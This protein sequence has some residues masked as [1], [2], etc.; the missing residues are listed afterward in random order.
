MPPKRKPPHSPKPSA[1]KKKA[2][3][4]KPTKAQNSPP[5]P[6][7]S[8]KTSQRST[9]TPRSKSL[10]EPVERPLFHIVGI[11]ASAGGLEAFEEFFTHMSPTSGL[12]FVVVPHQ[13]P[14]HASL[15]PSLLQKCTTMPVRE[16]VD[17]LLLE[18]NTVS[19]AL[20]GKNLGL[21]NGTLQVMEPDPQSRVPLPIDY[22]FRSLAVDQQQWAIGII[23][24]GTGSDGTLGLKTIKAES[25]FT[26]AQKPSSAKYDGMPQSAIGRG[27]VDLVCEPTDM[28]EQL[29]A[30]V[31]KTALSSGFALPDSFHNTA[32]E[33]Q[34][35]IMLLRDRT[36][37]DFSVYKSKT[38]ERRI[39]RR[40]N[41]HQIQT[42]PEYGRY[43]AAN[44]HESEVLF[45]E[46]LIGVT[47]F[48]RDPPVFYALVNQGFPLWFKSKSRDTPIRVWVPGCSTG[49][50][51]YTLAML[52]SEYQAKSQIKCPIQIFGTDL[53]SQAIATARTGLYPEGIANDVMSERLEQFFTQEDHHYRVKKA[54]RDM[55]IF[56]P[57]NVLTDPP[58]M[59][60][61]FI[62]CRNLFIYLLSHAQRRLIPLFHYALNP[63]GGLLLGSSETMSENGSNLFH[64]LNHKWKLY[65][66]QPGEAARPLLSGFAG[67]PVPV[68]VQP[69]GES[70]V[71]APSV[72]ALIETML[73]SKYAPCSVIVNVR[74][75]ITYIHGR[76][77]AYLEPASGQ[78]NLLLYKMAR[79]GLQ[80]DLAEALHQ[81]IRKEG[82][83]RR[84]G[85][86]VKTNGGF[87]LVDVTV[88]PIHDHDALRGLYLV[89]FAATSEPP[90]QPKTKK[91]RAEDAR[92]LKPA[93]AVVQELQF[94]KQRLQHVIEV[95][96]ATN[97]ELKSANEELQST[98]EE[99]Q[100]TNEELETS[101]EELQSL[102]EELTTVNTEYQAQIGDLD[103]ANDDLHN[104]L[105]SIEIP[106]VFLDNALNIKRFTPEIKNLINLIASDVG[107]P[108][109]DLGTKFSD[110]GFIQ[111]AQSVV[112]TLVF[113]EREVQTSDG[114]WFLRRILPYRTTKNVIDGLVITF[115]D[116]TMIKEAG[117]RIHEAKIYAEN[118]I[119]TIREPLLVLDHRLQVTSANEAF[120]QTFNLTP[121]SVVQHG[122]YEI[123]EGAWN[124]PTLR[125]LLDDI[126]PNNHVFQ[127]YRVELDI[128]KRGP[129]SFLLNARRMVEL[130]ELQPLI[131][132]AF[133]EVSSLD[134]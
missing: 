75:E 76:T 9:R 37:H 19:V 110:E 108:L 129:R 29:M 31:K 88:T 100:S 49:E 90:S 35:I 1:Q 30:Y 82:L 59:K 125:H 47:S 94:T 44:P 122:V 101:K 131:L 66:R 61:D 8:A 2:K 55:V 126:L 43:M 11:G 34:K 28:P 104:L 22:F 78:P 32:D 20:A 112:E 60:L 128:P 130:H 13:H 97:E 64:S 3:V 50:E 5:N 121:K 18:P 79:E 68:V 113:R 91:K 52:L 6:N 54:I 63:H 123:Q 27:S 124:I 111:E 92:P 21:L 62:S 96:Q 107:R 56:A 106:T 24:S 46:L 98:N 58:F 67:S 127:D 95:S 69:L 48:F 42:I 83:V 65:T 57:H 16:V 25:G 84:E 40:M 70:S 99:L 39:E 77:G 120:Y 85:I 81:S 17:G 71:P 117:L 86:Q 72:P 118:I 103:A 33:I 132:L 109:A 23:L 80:D 73:L 41:L 116:M 115:L 74:G 7:K 51:V 53:N 36:R 14:G 26:M 133:Q 38:I 119:E 12:A 105:N 10:D 102:N 114:H 45:Q 4:P 93:A 89:T 15:L 134:Q 87:S